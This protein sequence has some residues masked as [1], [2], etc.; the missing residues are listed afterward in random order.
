[1][2]LFRIMV[3]MR[4]EAHRFSRRLH[5]KN[6]KS[7]TFHSWLD[8]VVGVGEKTKQK[9]LKKSDLTLDELTELSENE[10]MN[11]FCISQKISKNIKKYLEDRS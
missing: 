5:H 3:Q 4:D 8:D 1:M 11:K 2:S 9:I 7:R 10:L 6:E